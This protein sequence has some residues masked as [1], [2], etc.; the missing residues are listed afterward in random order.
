M[1]SYLLIETCLTGD[2]HAVHNFLDLAIQLSEDNHAVD[3]F[4]IQN[5]VLLARIDG[6]PRLSALIRKPNVSVQV[7]DFS[8]LSHFLKSSDLIPGVKVAGMSTLVKML[9]QPNYKPIWH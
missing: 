3:L 2:S 5:G 6:E 7:D 1:S 4:L 9:T 8:L